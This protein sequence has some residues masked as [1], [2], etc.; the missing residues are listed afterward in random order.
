MHSLAVAADGS[1]FISWLD[2]PN[3]DVSDKP[4][5]K[6]H[7]HGAE[8]NRELFVASSTDGGKSFSAKQ[9]IAREVCPCC[10]TSLA[11][12]PG[13]RVYVSWRQALSGD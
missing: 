11:A 9:L 2:E 3:Q 1:I 8:R 7:K 5:K 12:G 10:K 4:E 6:G 13:G